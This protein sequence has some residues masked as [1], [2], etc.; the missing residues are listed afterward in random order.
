MIGVES[1]QKV[2]VLEVLHSGDEF[3]G[4]C[5]GGR[6]RHLWVSE[7]GVGRGETELRKMEVKGEDLVQVCKIVSKEKIGMIFGG[8]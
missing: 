3:L 4:F 2:V 5:L 6:D 8:G 7:W 1:L